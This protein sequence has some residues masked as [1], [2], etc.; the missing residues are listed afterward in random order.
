MPSHHRLC[1]LRDSVASVNVRFTVNNKGVLYFCA[2]CAGWYSSALPA[3]L[4]ET[5]YLVTE[6]AYPVDPGNT[7]VE[8]NYS[9]VTADNFFDSDGDRTAS[10]KIEGQIFSAT[11]TRGLKDNLD[12]ALSVSW[13]DV[14][15]DD[16]GTLADELGTVTVTAKYLFYRNETKDIAVSWLP[17]FTFP[18]KDSSGTEGVAPGQDF[19]SINNMLVLTYT[20][21]GFSASADVAVN[22]AVSGDRGDQV[23]EYLIDGAVGYQISPRLKAL[24][25]LNFTYSF[26]KN[27]SD[28]NV[29]SVVVGAVANVTNS[30]RVDLGIQYTMV[31]RDAASANIFLANFSKTF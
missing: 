11:A 13:R 27:L 6:D 26:L 10:G 7:E 21:E 2:I 5:A 30:F 29:G 28:A 25:E 9:Y 24:A 4:A 1:L 22:I 8:F 12:V 15:R 14:S 19:T 23:V 17:G 18:F 20:E 16:D 3:Q 31:G